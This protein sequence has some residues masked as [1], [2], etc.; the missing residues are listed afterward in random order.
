MYIYR[1]S[2]LRFERGDPEIG[3]QQ[4]HLRPAH[5]SPPLT[6][7]SSSLPPKR[8]LFK[9]R[10]LLLALTF[11]ALLPGAAPQAIAAGTV[12]ANLQNPQAEAEAHQKLAY[13]LPSAK[14]ARSRSLYYWRI[15]LDFGAPLWSILVLL[16]ILHYGWASALRGWA[17]RWTRSRWLQGLCFA[18]LLLLL[19]GL[20]HLPV[21]MVAHHVALT[22]GQSIQSWS[23]WLGDWTKALLLDLITGTIVLLVL[24]ALIRGSRR[25]W[26][27]L[28]L[29]SLPTQVVVVFL[30]PLVVDPLFNHFEPLS[31]RHPALVTQLERV[32]AKT[33]MQ[34]PPSRMYLMRASEKVTGSNA[35]V[36]GFGASKRVVVWDTTIKSCP[37]DEILL[38]F[39]HELGH[40][41]LKHIQRGLVIGSLLS[42]VFVWIGFRLSL[43][44]EKRYG[45]RWRVASID[46]WAAAAIL[47]LVV[48][49]LSFVAEPLENSISRAQEHQADV[50]GE[51]VVHGIVADPQ[52]V[53]ARS[54]QRLGEES[55]EYPTPNRFVVFWTYT[56]PPI[57][58]RETF[59][60]NYDPWQ[61][62]RQ[63]RY[64]TEDGQLLPP[65]FWQ[66]R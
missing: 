11:L 5:C 54:F 41:V 21:G 65:N 50:F 34:I 16:A 38:I 64:F 1:Q 48:S 47:L 44:F 45:A 35:Y 32:A 62:G 19:I 29:L 22:Y 13:T 51:E 17:V 60:A 58:V 66:G 43:L 52:R 9:R 7:C 53:A 14:L 15:A 24:F 31:A 8:A 33:G 46:D 56:H 36:T 23:S 39:G 10:P 59:A 49:I 6:R 28:W 57:A 42:F 12:T 2:A 26:L 4:N 40:Y 3:E 55:L 18:P 37:V 30:L 63:P 27:W 20:L 61:P 25:W